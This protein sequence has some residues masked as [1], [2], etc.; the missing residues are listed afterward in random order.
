MTQV[1][2]IETQYRWLL[3]LS[4]FAVMMVISI[5]QYSWFLFS[6][7]IQ[8]DYGWSLASLGLV[9]TIFHYTSTL[10]Q[11]FSG[12]IADTFSPRW[13][14]LGAALLVG[15]GFI[16]CSIF[17]SVWPFSIYYGLGGFG[18]GILYG[19]S[20][21][22]AIKWFPDKRGFATGLVVFGFGAGTALFNLAIE[23]SLLLNGLTPTFRYLGIIML[24]VLIPLSL[25]YRY[26]KD[27]LIMPSKG[28]GNPKKLKDA[29]DFKPLAMLK[30]YQWYLIYFSFSF[31]ISI[32]LIFG[33]QMK[34]LAV[35]YGLPDGYFKILLIC[36][37]LANGLSRVIA[38]YVSDI[39][40]RAKTMVVFY[41]LLGISVFALVLLGNIP[42]LFFLFVI[43][44]SLLGG[45]PFVLY[46]TTIGDFYGPKYSTTNYGIT[47]TAK[48]LAG[49]ISGWL[50]GYLV[51]QFGSFKL[52][53]IVIALLSIV[54]ALI[55]LP[56]FMKAPGK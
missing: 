15:A 14:A 26:P 49:L 29:H 32:V 35:E 34:V 23:K 55:S 21:A 41:S 20:T 27:N 39:I 16:L 7:K 56:K 46:P 53:L 24:L 47:Y 51:M 10:I 28:S 48:S 52:P 12:Y 18:G 2:M 11:P 44:A 25:V 33:A 40:G 42:I 37:P 1:P 13:V 5:Y 31:T 36:F 22:T 6:F 19:I 17:P 54:S 50:S 8:A 9:Y 43:I 38:G 4:A 3:L 45:A 30:T